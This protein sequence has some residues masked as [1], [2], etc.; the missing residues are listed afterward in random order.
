MVAHG[1]VPARPAH[2]IASRSA[3][4]PW[5]ETVSLVAFATAAFD[6]RSLTR[7]EMNVRILWG[8]LAV[9]LFIVL[10]TTWSGD[11][12]DCVAPRFPGSAWNAVVRDRWIPFYPPPAFFWWWYFYDAYAN[13]PPNHSLTCN[14]RDP[15]GHKDTY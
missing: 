6:A 13:F 8:Q 15:G 7:E 1:Y 14:E 10:A 11:A 3:I 2:V 12:V 4:E 9:V 5:V